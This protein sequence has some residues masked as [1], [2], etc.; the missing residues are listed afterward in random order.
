M[1]VCQFTFSN[2]EALVKNRFSNSVR[3]INNI[4][5][6]PRE[7]DIIVCIL[8]GRASKSSN[9]LIQR[10]FEIIL[11]KQVKL[12]SKDNS[13]CLIIYPDEKHTQNYLL[14]DSND[15]KLCQGFL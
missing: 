7:I 14:S 11:K 1:K 3:I 4:L 15:T 2:I 10:H 6:V 9:L 8:A 12:N 5:F 13:S